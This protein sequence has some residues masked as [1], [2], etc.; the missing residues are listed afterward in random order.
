MIVREGIAT[1]HEKPLGLSKDF[2]ITI[3]NGWSDW[4]ED[5]NIK[6]GNEKEGGS[7]KNYRPSENTASKC[8]RNLVVLYCF[9]YRLILHLAFQRKIT[10]WKLS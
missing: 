6:Q 2:P 4:S 3:D 5:E 7:A 10:P 9:K 1:K 8:R